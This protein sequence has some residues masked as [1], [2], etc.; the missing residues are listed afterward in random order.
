MRLVESVLPIVLAAGDSTRMGYPKALLPLGEDLFITRILKALRDTGLPR[1]IVI[2]GRAAPLI[3]PRIQGWPADV[4]I[5][6]DP[7]RGQLSSI[8]LALENLGPEYEACMIWPVDQPA[9]SEELVRRLARLFLSSD[10]KIVFPICGG[11]RGHPAIFHR[12]LFQEFMDAP[13]S[14][15]PKKILFRHQRETSELPTEESATVH[16]IDT[17]LDYQAL[18]GKSLEAALAERAAKSS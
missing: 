9:V 16:D 14:E 10:S 12:D 8:Q 11:K 17:P 5:N 18:T 3:Q 13:L 2:L 6:H 1:P 15:G 7:N 4:R